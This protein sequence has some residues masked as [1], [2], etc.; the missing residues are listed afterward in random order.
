MLDHGPEG[1][2][3]LSLKKLNHCRGAENAEKNR[4]SDII[5]VG[6]VGATHASPRGKQS[7]GTGKSEMGMN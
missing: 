7:T 2:R 1:T 5:R 4:V 6:G 3:V